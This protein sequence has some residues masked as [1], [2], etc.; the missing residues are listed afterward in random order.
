[1]AQY[2]LQQQ[3]IERMRE[4][5]REIER[6][7]EYDYYDDPYFYTPPIYRY[8]RGGRYYE[9]NEYG[10]KAM[11]RA[12]QYG[13]E[14]GYR[15]GEADREDGWQPSYRD[16]YA[17]QDADYGYDGRYLDHDEYA[18]YFRE[19][20]RRGYADG[21]GSESRYGS[22]SGGKYEILAEVL[23]SILGLESR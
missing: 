22:A 6:E 2:R 8:S 17:Y 1:M 13:Y 5:Q 7:R 3:Y 20:F 18:Y 16:A 11:R 14:E 21:Y 10:A 12:V 4:Q 19:G 9:T 23:S 15:A